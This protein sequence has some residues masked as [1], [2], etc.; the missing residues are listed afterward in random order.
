MMR[1][2]WTWTD[3]T[4]SGMWLGHL[5]W[6]VLVGLGV[7]FLIAQFARAGASQG[8]G[9]LGR[10]ALDILEERFAKGEIDKDE[11]ELRRRTLAGR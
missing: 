5:A 3:W 2:Y 11:F 1:D 6:I 10:S 4:W 7:W 9:R 8:G